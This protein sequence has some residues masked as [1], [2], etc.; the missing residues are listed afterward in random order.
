MKRFYNENLPSL[1]QVIICVEHASNQ[2]ETTL[3]RSYSH[4]EE[5]ELMGFK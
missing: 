5:E 2:C 3:S 1:S 4:K